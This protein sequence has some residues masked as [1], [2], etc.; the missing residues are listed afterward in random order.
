MHEKGGPGGCPARLL[1]LLL[2]VPSASLCARLGRDDV[3]GPAAV[4][5][6]ELNRA[7][8]QREQRVVAA[9]ADALAGV[10]VRAALADE[11]LARVHDLTA[12]TLDAEALGL[13]VAAVAAGR[14]ALL[15]CHLRPPPP[16]PWPSPWPSACCRCRCQ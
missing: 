3:H 15:V 16:S 7:A 13:G 6:G 9:A 11:D 8:D 5:P 4:A 1:V 10:E 14:G 12:V 2:C